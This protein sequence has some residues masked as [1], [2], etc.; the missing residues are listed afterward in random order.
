MA[1][2]LKQQL[3]VSVPLV[4]TSLSNTNVTGR[5]VPTKQVSR[6]LAILHG[7]AAA[8]TKTWK[9]ELLEA[10]DSAGTGASSVSST[11]GTANT[12]VKELTIALASIANTDVVTVNGVDFVKAAASSGLEFADAAG[13]KSAIEANCEGLSCA[14]NTTTVTVTAADGY[15]V[16]ASK[17][18]TAGTITLATTESVTILEIVEADF[19]S[20]TTHV[21]PKVTVTGVGVY[22]VVLVCDMKSLPDEQGNLST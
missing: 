14:V 20:T 16:T 6:I 11:T 4:A 18:E 15:T 8:A 1:D 22:G 5:Y 10:T 9:L 7:G 19:A 17:T 13:L 3:H 2:K 21:A 12:K